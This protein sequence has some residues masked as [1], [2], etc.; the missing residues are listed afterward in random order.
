MKTCM[1]RAP[2]CLC[3]QENGEGR[4]GSSSR[5]LA[6]ST[7]GTLSS[8]PMPG[9]RAKT[10]HWRPD[11]IRSSI[12][13]TA[14]LLASAAATPLPPDLLAGLLWRNI[15]PF[16]GGRISAAS[17]AIG[18]V[19]TFYVGLPGSGV[20]KTTSAGAAWVP[21]FDAVT[22]S[23]SVGAVEVA[24]S[25]AKVIYVGMGD[26]IGFFSLNEGDG[27]YRSADAGQTWQHLG[28]DAARRIPSIIVDPR[29]ADVVLVA[30]L[31][32]LR[33]KGD[34]RGVFRSSDG[35]ATW[36][37]TL[38]SSDST[39]VAKLA[40]AYDRPDVVFATTTVFYV[41][42]LPPSGVRPPPKPPAPNAPTGGGLFKSV[43]G[44]VTWRELT[45]GGVPRLDGRTAVAVAM[46]TNAQRVYVITNDGLF[47]SDD[48]G[49]TWR[50][51]DPSDRRIR[52]G[53]GGYNCGVLVDPRDPDVV[54][55]FN[56]S[57]YKSTD[58]GASFTG[59]KGAPGGDDPQAGWIDPTNG[60][61]ILLG[62]DQGAI[63]SLDGG[64]T[65]SSWYNQSTEQVYHVSTDNSFPYWVYA[66]QQ[67]AGAIRTRARGNLGAVTPLDWSPVNGWEWG[68]IVPDPRDPNTV[69]A[70]GYGLIKI[71]FPSAQW[72]SVSPAADAELRLRTSLSQPLVW[73]P[74]DQRELLT[75]FQFVMATSDGGA[76]WRM[77][78]PDLT[79]AA[80]V[81]PPPDTATPPK[82]APPR[83]AIETIAASSVAPGTIWVG[84]TN[85]LIKL[86]RDFGKT[87]SDATIPN[88]PYP[89]RALIEKVEASPFDAAGAYA[90]V[91]LLRA[92]DYTPYVYRTRDSGR[93]WQLITNGLP[94]T[95]ASGSSVRVVRAD[96]KRAGLLVAGTESGMFVS[97]DDGDA[98]QSLQLNLPTTSYRDIAFADNDLIVGTY[99]RGIWV[100]DDYA[101]LRQM[102][103]DVAREAVRLF[104]PDPVV[105]VRRNVNYNTPFPPEVPHAPNP[106]EGA[107]IYYWLR[108]KP[109]G[110]ITLDVTDASGAPVRHLSSAPAAPVKEAGQPPHPNFWVAEPQRLPVAVGTNRTSWDLRYDPP[111]AFVHTF[112]IN[113]NPGLTPAS[114]L[115]ALVAPGTYTVKLTV[116]GRGYS[117]TVTVTNDPRSPA[118]AADV[119]AQLALQDRLAGAMRVAWDGYRQVAAM[120]GALDSLKPADST[121]VLAKAVAAF[122]ARLDSVGGTDRK[123]VV[124]G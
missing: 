15:G 9:K 40:I 49:T 122:R 66:T 71:S 62:Y 41:P 88:L 56:T 101:V 124:E 37:K 94:T 53:Q 85:G 61:R 102:T 123:S 108:S 1:G 112:E 32:N 14:L 80:G 75:G 121:T 57:A 43:D 93:T 117:Q 27:V 3:G 51:M 111:P 118:T 23:S 120:R 106:P 19:G 35:G 34:V 100:L 42:P 60:R 110:E 48:G 26:Q 99:G 4:A 82:D 103:P 39:G 58:G 22:S 5:S 28:L 2:G 64:T 105:R 107:I 79:Y 74:W 83:G 116:D 25:N 97:F 98:W 90:V 95:R 12:V 29:N 81:T 46:N 55:T 68:T 104:Q 69:Y 96:P 20:W 77:L 36:H 76:H 109:A 7:D 65:W 86:T 18:D 70:S 50:H 21:V 54:Y 16:R 8:I 44:G 89:A 67:D 72:I 73:A 63:V 6:S 84:T 92:G 115:G 87:W 30:A 52:N 24:P 47:R 10:S 114:P 17:G 45:G 11:M 119:R 31:G 33:A 59:F 13:A 38:Y 91:D 113:A 78:S